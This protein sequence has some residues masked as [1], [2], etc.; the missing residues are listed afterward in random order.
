MSIHGMRAPPSSVTPL[1]S[2]SAAVLAPGGGELV[3]PTHNSMLQFWDAAQGQHV[4]KLQVC[5]TKR[6]ES[7][8]FQA[9]DR[10]PCT[11]NLLPRCIYCIYYAYI[12]VATMAAMLHTLCSTVRVIGNVRL[13]GIKVVSVCCLNDQLHVGHQVQHCYVCMLACLLLTNRGGALSLLPPSIAYFT[14]RGKPVCCCT[15][16]CT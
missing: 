16:A 9:T 3:M 6:Q 2:T 7:S 10:S 8:C 14:I 1:E 12:T 13:L 11:P 15:E 4:G 5:L